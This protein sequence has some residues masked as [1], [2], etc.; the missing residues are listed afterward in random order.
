[1]KPTASSPGSAATA[2]PPPLPPSVL[3]PQPLPSRSPPELLPRPPSA[4]SLL[5]TSPAPSPWPAQDCL[6]PPHAASLR[7]N[8]P[9]HPPPLQPAPS[10]FKQT[11]PRQVSNRVT[12]AT[13]PPQALPLFCFYP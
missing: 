3:A 1:M 5:T 7:R 10:R 2:P 13:P 9:S 12:F 11:P 6:R 4:S 8:L